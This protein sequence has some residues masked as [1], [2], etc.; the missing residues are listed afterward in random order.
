[1][2]RLMESL[3][4]LPEHP[5]YVALIFVVAAAAMAAFTFM[6]TTI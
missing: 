4:E 2:R 5:V 3:A 1:M 6:A